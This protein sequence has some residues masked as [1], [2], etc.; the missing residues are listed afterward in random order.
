MFGGL[1][2]G[3]IRHRLCACVA[4]ASLALSVVAADFEPVVVELKLNGVDIGQVLLLRAPG[5]V[6]YASD[7]D[8][9]EWQLCHDR[10]KSFRYRNKSFYP[11]GIGPPVR[12]KYDAGQQ[13]LEIE[14]PAA[15]FA[16]TDIN[17]RRHASTLTPSSP[18]AFL[19][20]DFF[21]SGSA[22]DG[23]A[24]NSISGLIEAVGFNSLGS[25]TTD[26]IAPNL[27][28]G[29]SVT[30]T[31]STSL[32]RLD[33]TF[34]HDNAADMTRWEV[35]DAIGGS[36]I[37][38]RPIR[39]AGI[40]FSRNFDTTPGFV[41]EPLPQ[42]A[43]Q[44][45]LPSTVEVYLNGVLQTRQQVQPGPFQI[46]GISTFGAG[47]TVQLV[48]H[49]LL[50][51]EVITTLPFVTGAP[52]LRQ[53]LSDFSIEAGSMREDYGARSFD[54]SGG[55]FTATGRYGISDALTVEARSETQGDQFTE[56]VGGSFVVPW[57]RYIVSGAIAGSRSATGSGEQE[58]V[59]F[60]PGVAQPV[61]IAASLQITDAGFVQLG[62][63]PNQL[64]PRYTGA[65]SLSLPLF[66][67]LNFS[68]SQVRNAPRNTQQTVVN[69]VG[70]QKSFAHIGSVSLS[71][72]ITKAGTSNKGLLMAVTLGLGGN[73]DVISSVNLQRTADEP[74]TSQLQVEFDRLPVS[75]LGWGWDVRAIRD[76]SLVPD[77]QDQVGAGGVYQ[78]RSLAVSGQ[79]D[80]NGNRYRYQADVSGA[81]VVMA[82]QIF[83]T[84]RIFDS[85]G[86]AEAPDLP[87][88]PVYVENQLVGY[89][90][91]KGEVLLP[92]LI[93]FTDNKVSI[94]ANDLPFDAELLGSDSITVAPYY[95][96]GVVV[97][98]PVHRF[99]SALVT[100]VQAD[101]TPV[102]LGAQ[103][104][105]QDGGPDVYVAD[106][107][108]SY[109]RNVL[110]RGN[111]LHISWG[112]G[113]ACEVRFDLPD[114]A[115]AQPHV[116]PLI[117][118]ERP[119]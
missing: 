111:L 21:A 96:S 37:W 70:M 36:S 52:L 69:S 58:T 67:H 109:L 87:G 60:Q 93:E 119:Q 102:P 66:R 33:S 83:A 118:T 27:L 112:D 88:L 62:T 39:F 10:G 68:V 51:Q 4:A 44:A 14:L 18:G 1:R 28:S 74:L 29:V 78:G 90:N 6:F 99:R 24:A 106:R 91:S 77:G 43:G 32:V 35:G 45:E 92:R 113:H 26:A 9:G 82:D 22:G 56:G 30:D 115:R 19:N 75:E 31:D 2:A 97:K 50:G 84:R 98:L 61:S 49:D 47:G 89:T 79:L 114:T 20:Y 42:V 15:C 11:P 64:P 17:L 117:C 76:D 95:R 73:D 53:G 46:D 103:V 16:P 94:E 101:G 7:T 107:G 85:F 25:F 63:L 65:V 12:Q 100:L 71:A 116:G 80:G 38:G 55:F 23:P 108:E 3:L 72:F 34:T 5:D 110:P 48:V 86:V 8:L 81:F 59:S 54:Y 105:Y 104:T 57:L 13:T 41:T 40:R